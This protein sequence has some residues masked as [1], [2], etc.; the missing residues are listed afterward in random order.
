[1]SKVNLNK[2]SVKQQGGQMIPTE[3]GMRNEPQVDPVV[4]QMTEQIQ[5]SV[6]GGQDII[7]V[8]VSLTEQ[9]NDQQLISQA[10]MM[11]GMQEQDIFLCLNK[12]KKECNLHHHLLHQR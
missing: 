7:D 10:L 8:V 5:M 12:Y 2:I 6:Q 3:P 4:M 9:G 11:G 1:M